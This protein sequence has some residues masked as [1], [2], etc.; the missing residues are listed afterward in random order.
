MPSVVQVD[1][2][3]LAHRISDRCVVCGAEFYRT[4][5][6]V[7]KHR[8]HDRCLYECSWTCFR[9]MERKIEAGGG[10]NAR[11]GVWKPEDEKLETERKPVD[12]ATYCRE[13]IALYTQQIKAAKT[14]LQRKYAKNNVR[15]WERKLRE[16]LR[17]EK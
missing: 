14:G 13:K 5:E 11:K 2:L 12:R 8:K 9:A 16:A 3:G 6:H 17:N 7:Y 15:I 10:K 4:V 1:G